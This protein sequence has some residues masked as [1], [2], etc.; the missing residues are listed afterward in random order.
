MDDAALV[1]AACEGS[2]DA[3]ADIYDRYSER[4][5]TFLRTVMRN[6]EDAADVL[7]ETFISAGVRIH[8]L[9][10]PEKL[11]PWLYAIA[12][13]KALRSLSRAKQHEPL[14]GVEVADQAADPSKTASQDE[15]A[16]LIQAAAEGLSPRDRVLLDLHLRQGLEGQELGL[17][18]G[19]SAG[20]AH[21]MLSRMRDQVERSM[22]ALLVARLGRKDCIEL[23]TILIDWDGHFTTTWRKRVARHV[24]GCATCGNLRKKALSP[25]S[26]LS[27]IPFLKPPSSVRAK[28]LE[29][30]QLVG[31]VSRL[32]VSRAEAEPRWQRDGFPP[33]IVQ[34]RRRNWVGATS[35]IAAVIVLIAALVWSVDVIA[36]GG[37]QG[38][39][40]PTAFNAGQILQGADS[41]DPEEAVESTA[42]PNPSA[43][44]ASALPETTYLPPVK[45]AG[46]S[47]P[48]NGPVLQESPASPREP[49][50]QLGVAPSDPEQPGGGTQSGEVAASP[51]PSPGGD[52]AVDRDP[53]AL[54]IV[55]IDP[56]E[57]WATGPCGEGNPQRSSITASAIDPSGIDNVTLS[58]GGPSPG[59]M[60]MSGSGGNGY[61]GVVG[62]FSSEAIAPGQSVT[63][64]ITI[65]ARDAA[66][67]TTTA[68]GTLKLTCDR[69]V[70]ARTSS[71]SPSPSP[72]PSRR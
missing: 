24:D 52:P 45:G 46:G 55:R 5:Y 31:F 39:A 11:R 41:Q 32:E 48:Q 44:A 19:V 30:V 61:S 20:H 13:H 21:V 10:N 3:F 43:S 25:V 72:P 63:I 7:Q 66:G 60:T 53:P 36:Q 16:E 17:A 27:T 51:D 38:V 6:P 58:Y 33:P 64:P 59:S 1:R 50:G 65:R 18:L 37:A 67:N 12:R 29:E 42:T 26:L 15:L 40:Q 54:R 22:G 34:G 47:A 23:K 35:K 56:T 28:V 71:S 9:K 68:G 70:E 14:E 57:I 69:T 62:P 49:S 4:I 8:Q 2:K